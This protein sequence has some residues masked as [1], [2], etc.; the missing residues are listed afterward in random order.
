LR[1]VAEQL[2]SR[3]SRIWREVTY[4]LRARPNGDVVDAR[5][6]IDIVGSSMAIGGHRHRILGRKADGVA[7]GDVLDPGEATMS[8]AAA[9]S[10]SMRLRPSKARAWSPWSAHASR[11]ERHTTDLAAHLHAPA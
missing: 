1:H 4:C 5:T 2:A 8:P 7:D 9:S 3:R 10:M 6:I 11:R